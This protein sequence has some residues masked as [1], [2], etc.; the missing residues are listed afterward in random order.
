MGLF[1]VAVAG[2][3]DISN[4]HDGDQGRHGYDNRGF[5]ST[6]KRHGGR[7]HVSQDGVV[8]PIHSHFSSIETAL[9]KGQ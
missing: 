1:T 3:L 7:R 5:A 9:E 8:V 2:F 6:G 4:H